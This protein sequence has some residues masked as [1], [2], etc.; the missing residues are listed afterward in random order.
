MVGDVPVGVQVVGRVWGDE[1][2]L[3]VCRVL[4]FIVAGRVPPPRLHA[5]ELPE[6]EAVKEKH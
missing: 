5:Y 3:D 1:E 4:E 2:L 6:D